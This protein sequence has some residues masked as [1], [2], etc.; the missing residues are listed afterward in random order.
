MDGIDAALIHVDSVFPTASEAARAD[1]TRMVDSLRLPGAIR[2][3]S[4]VTWRGPAMDIPR[5]WEV[6]LEDGRLTATAPGCAVL[7]LR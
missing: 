1:A 2:L 5:P 3:K 4:K 7:A 6:E